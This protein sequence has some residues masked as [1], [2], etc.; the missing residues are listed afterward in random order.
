MRTRTMTGRASQ[1]SGFSLIEVMI[2]VAII[3]VLA[4]IGGPELSRMIWKMRLQEA[5]QAVTRTLNVVRKVS[6]ANNARH[7]V[8]FQSDANSANGGP[9]F[10]MAVTVATEPTLGAGTWTNLV[11]PDERAGWTNNGTTPLYKGVSIE[12]GV[13]TDAIT[14]IDGC[15]GFLFNNQGFL[16]NGPGD[17]TSDCDGSS[18]S[19]GAGCIRLTLIQ[20]ALNNERRA[21]WIDRGGNVRV[22]SSPSVEPVPP[23]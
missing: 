16:E 2:A 13:N 12:T 19:A 9:D 8:R 17:F 14:G 21:L 18:S 20:K 3:A 11:A 22:S 4:L 5:T 1:E 7:C 10:F 15:T 23:T 6:M